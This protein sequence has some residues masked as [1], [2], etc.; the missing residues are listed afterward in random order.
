MPIENKIKMG[1]V[2]MR[3]VYTLI[4]LFSMVITFAVS[5]ALTKDDVGENK[6]ATKQ[7]KE[8]IKEVNKKLDECVKEIQRDMGDLAI[9][10]AETRTDVKTIKDDNKYIKGR[11]DYLVEQLAKNNRES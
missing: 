10:G 7:N 9:S 11:L 5:Q 4:I 6:V 1:A 2:A 8:S 3:M